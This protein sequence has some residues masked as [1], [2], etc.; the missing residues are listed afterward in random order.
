MSKSPATEASVRLDPVHDGHPV[1]QAFL[2]EAIL[3]LLSFPLITHPR[4]VLSLILNRPTDI[5]PSLVLFTRLF[6]GIVVGGLTP[7]LLYGYRNTRQAI[8]TR[9][10]VYIS[11]GLG[12]VL[13]IPVLIGELL[14]GGQGDA[15][16]SMRGAAGA[17]MCLA[18][19]LAWRIYVLVF[20]PQLLG[21]YTELKKE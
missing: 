16:L 13:L 19:P 17:I 4:F 9:K 10:Q 5:N 7:G 6:G 15:A 12:E 2:I 8:E 20:K 18:P 3:N 11:L 14:K 21:R 1:R